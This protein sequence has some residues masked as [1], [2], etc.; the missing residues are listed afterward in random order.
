LFFVFAKYITIHC[1]R[2]QAKRGAEAT[3]FFGTRQGTMNKRMNKIQKQD[4]K[5]VGEGVRRR[6]AARGRDKWDKQ[7]APAWAVSYTYNSGRKRTRKGT[8]KRG[9]NGTVTGAS[10][11]RIKHPQLQFKR[12]GPPCFS[13]DT[14][15][16]QGAFT[17]GYAS[18]SRSRYLYKICLF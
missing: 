18:V 5:G 3:S 6:H 10:L 13:P 17:G 15:V 9:T 12:R 2:Q 7:P 16:L 8:K 4:Q 1:T 14:L 11:C